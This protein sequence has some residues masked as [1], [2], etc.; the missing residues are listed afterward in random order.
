MST[1]IHALHVTV[2]CF[3]A[4]ESVSHACPIIHHPPRQTQA[5]NVAYFR[6]GAYHGVNPSLRQMK[7]LKHAILSHK[8][9]WRTSKYERMAIG[10]QFPHSRSHTYPAYRQA[11]GRQAPLRAGEALYATIH[12]PPPPN[13]TIAAGGGP[14]GHTSACALHAD[15]PTLLTPLKPRQPRARLSYTRDRM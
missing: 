13:G 3:H 5:E 7:R 14:G 8:K 9:C 1:S 4:H 2:P 11:G 6:H 12:S 15:R 10:N